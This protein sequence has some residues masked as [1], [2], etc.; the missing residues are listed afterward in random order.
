MDPYE[1]LGIPR[2]ATSEAVK[3]AYRKRAQQAHPDRDS[4]AGSGERFQAIQRAYEVLSDPE[5]RAQYDATGR[6]DEAP[7]QESQAMGY[8]ATLLHGMLDSADVAHTDMVARM[9]AQCQ[10]DMATLDQQTAMLKKQQARRRTVLERLTGERMRAI[11]EAEIG[12]LDQA[13]ATLTGK[14]VI[15]KRAQEIIAEHAYRTDG[16]EEQWVF[17]Y[18]AASPVV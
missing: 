4:S 5:R 12:Q 18:G 15:L 2:G 13:I 14:V 10:T 8:V 6:M 11:V 1:V 3:A 16:V 17:G 9:R 7:D